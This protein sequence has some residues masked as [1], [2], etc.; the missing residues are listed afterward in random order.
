MPWIAY[1][2]PLS[3]EPAPSD[4][5]EFRTWLLQR[6]RDTSAPTLR[7]YMAFFTYPDDELVALVD[8]DGE[9]GT[10]LERIDGAW[11][12]LEDYSFESLNGLP[13]DTVSQDLVSVFDAA[14]SDNRTLQ[15]SEVLQFIV[16]READA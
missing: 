1:G 11:V 8:F 3:D 4:P 13:A 14:E 12:P 2:N 6:V 16:T 9:G 10:S 15:R 5:D 7:T